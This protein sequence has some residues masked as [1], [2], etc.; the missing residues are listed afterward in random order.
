MKYAK[1]VRDLIPARIERD[2]HIP[3][4]HIA[5]TEE[6]RLKLNDKL[7]EEATEFSEKPSLEEL[8]DLMEV[9]QAICVE[10]GWSLV[11]LEKTRLAK[12]E[13]RGGFS[14]RIIL[15]ETKEG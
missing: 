6:Y 2:G 13:E 12:F 8:A 3:I 5:D 9:V 14:E 4:T 10:Y 7:H 15:D 11:D 1:L